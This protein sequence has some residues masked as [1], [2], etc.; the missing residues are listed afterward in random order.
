MNDKKNTHHT[1]SLKMMNINIMWWTSY[2]IL[3]K[4][5]MVQITKR[6][7]LFSLWSTP[8][9]YTSEALNQKLF[10]GP[11]CI[12]P[13][14]NI[15]SPSPYGKNNFWRSGVGPTPVL[16]SSLSFSQH[17]EALH[18]GVSGRHV[19]P[20]SPFMGLWHVKRDQS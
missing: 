17:S 15:S 20:R 8:Q 10:Y 9:P 12:N 14:P 13:G 1:S 4:K 18:V 6:A 3:L 11:E 5:M 7:Q 2:W 16:W 19:F